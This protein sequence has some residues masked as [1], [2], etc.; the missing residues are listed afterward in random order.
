MKLINSQEIVE[1][2]QRILHRFP[3]TT[4]FLSILN[5]WTLLLVWDFVN[6]DGNGTGWFSVTSDHSAIIFYY[7]CTASVLDVV[8]NLLGEEMHSQRRFK[9]ISLTVHA[10]LCINALVLWNLPEESITESVVVAQTA[11][12]AALFICGI[13]LPFFRE[14][15]D[16]ASWNFTLRMGV[17]AVLCTFACCIVSIGLVGLLWSIDRLFDI[18]VDNRWNFTILTLMML[19]VAP[20][21][22]LSRFPEKSEKHDRKA[23]TWKFLSGI[24]R[25]LFLPLVLL[26]MAVLYVYVIRIAFLTELPRGGVCRMVNA[27][28]LG[29]IA[30][31][32]LLYPQQHASAGHPEELRSFEL[33][34][35]RWMP[36]LALPLLVL[37]SIAIGR[38]IMDYGIT[39]NRLYMA[40]LNL[41]FYGVCIGLIL[42]RG[43]RIHWIPLSFA[44]L[45]FVTSSLP[46][47]FY[48]ITRHSILSKIE[49][50]LSEHGNPAL[51]MDQDNYDIFT[52]SLKKK[53]AVRLSG[54]LLY[55]EKLGY[56]KDVRKFV[57]K[58]T[59]VWQSINE[60]ESVRTIA[61]F[62]STG[63]VQVPEGFTRF[64][65]FSTLQQNVEDN[66]PRTW[67]LEDENGNVY[68]IELPNVE[69]YKGEDMQ[70]R[71]YSKDREAVLCVTE[72]VLSETNYSNEKN[73]ALR[74]EGYTFEK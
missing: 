29:L 54:Q 49:R 5:L 34:A 74:L 71:F 33:R 7:L 66:H 59:Y 73:Y 36:F 63:M 25:W 17:F 40:T 46:V 18:S 9:A 16:I 1:G 24:V 60:E 52:K 32:I 20:C 10:L 23:Q 14:K 70:L 12:T 47:N 8:M 44:A 69:K 13:F 30:I 65:S 58:D 57:T 45:A 64:Q 26:Y 41:W 61:E 67:I 62:N 43:H 6:L 28:M 3:A 27:F 72:F 4:T 56:D 38:R 48:S 53:N 37:M 42:F 22:W 39:V 19:A 31:V 2:L 51:P 15:D 11:F 68:H 50:T 35:M 55:L 21:I